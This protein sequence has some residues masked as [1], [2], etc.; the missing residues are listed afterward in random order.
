MDW[1]TIAVVPLTKNNSD[2]VVFDSVNQKVEIVGK[3]NLKAEMIK[4]IIFNENGTA[5]FTQTTK[6][7]K[8]NP[9]IRVMYFK[10][11]AKFDVTFYK[12]HLN[13]DWSMNYD[14]LHDTHGLMGM[15]QSQG[16]F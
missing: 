7:Q 14:V 12:N 2:A 13:M 6:K 1:K 15:K 9:V 16:R 8:G 3:G 4:E 5:K 10:V 11:H